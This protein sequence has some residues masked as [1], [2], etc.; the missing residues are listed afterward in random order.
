MSKG[1]RILFLEDN[2][3]DEELA[4]RELRKAQINF[5]AERVE[6]REDF[7][8]A[9]S[10]F[11]PDIVLSDYSLPQ[12]NGLEALRLVRS[13]GPGI[14]FILITGSLTEEV[15]V[16]CMKAG[17]DDYILKTSLKRLPS[18]VLNVLSKREAEIA[19]KHAVRAMRQ[20]EDLYRLIAENSRDLICMIDLRG[21][22]I[23]AS[24]S[25]EAVLGYKPEE[26]LGT[27][28]FTLVHP[29]DVDV[30]KREF[31]EALSRRE[32]R[33]AEFRFRNCAGGWLHF[34][35]TGNWIFGAGGSPE[36]AVIVSRDVTE[37]K[38]AEDERDAERKLLNSLI[39]Q[40][41]VGILFRDARGHYVR[42][43]EM[44]SQILEIGL[45]RL[46][47]MKSEELVEL[48]MPTDSVGT[49]VTDVNI[50][51]SV[52]VRQRK[53]VQATEMLITTFAGSKRRVVVQAAP[54]AMNGAET[55]GSVVVISD[56]TEQ[57]GVAEKLR[58]AQRIE[59]IGILAGGVA[60]DFN[61]LLTVINGYSDLALRRLPADDPLHLSISEIRKAG[62]RA[63]TLTRQLLAFSRKQVLQPQVMDINFVIGEME[64]L[65][66]R[67]IREDI[68][69]ITQTTT[70]P[71]KIKADKGQL[72][73]VLMNLV[74]NAR[75]A[76]PEGGKLVVETQEVY[77]DE[78][79]ARQHIAV[80][81]GRY[82]MVAVSDTGCGMDGETRARMFEPFFTTKEAGK[83]TGLGLSTVYGIVK[84]SGGNIW[85][86]SEVGRGTTFKIYLPSVNQSVEEE[87]F[88]SATEALPRGGEKVL[89]AE[90]EDMLRG[91]AATI[92]RDQG[93]E[94]LEARDGEEALRIFRELG[95]DRIHMLLTDSVMPRMNG[96]QLAEQLLQACPG[97]RVLFM[98]GYTDLAVVNHGILAEGASFLQKPFTPEGLARKVREVLDA[99]RND[100]SYQLRGDGG[101]G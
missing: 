33:T 47:G 81:P 89:L 31:A 74:I 34:E 60:H 9:L 78:H 10:D 16:E 72:E 30:V 12:F 93:Y 26:L 29:D 66:S 58:Q 46:V 35:A 3:H 42:A 51:S 99:P 1:Y 24:P 68:A 56:I 4:R 41:P 36:R 95:G 54:V 76:M 20:S 27:S 48:V 83:G 2:P 37:R 92:L 84:Q 50:P 38:R 62:A 49:P 88:G 67:L 6:T 63:A 32:G 71:L 44:A 65:L 73:Q 11:R 21:D 8:R 5:T 90:D 45:D 101:G 15:A 55:L 22:Y 70:V 52:S 91:L 14:P 17:A 79:Y 77:L 53:A 59:S 94:V 64:K 98:S 40:L 13:G 86:Y 69:L 43:N 96:T 97:M 80:H 28:A 61:N 100:M 19:K 39:N 75:D 82:A 25:H 23:Y 7:V 85:V 18:A 87:R 57:H